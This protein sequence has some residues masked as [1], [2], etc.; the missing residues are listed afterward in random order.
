MIYIIALAFDVH[1]YKITIQ[2]SESIKH[3]TPRQLALT[4]FKSTDEIRLDIINKH[5]YPIKINY[6]KD[7]IFCCG[8]Y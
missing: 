2:L 3:K 5:K 7:Q 1:S 6:I 4:Y 8:A